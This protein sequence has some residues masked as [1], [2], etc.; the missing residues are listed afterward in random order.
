MID[1]DKELQEIQKNVETYWN[2]EGHLN[3][4]SMMSEVVVATTSGPCRDDDWA[5]PVVPPAPEQAAP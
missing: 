4:W 5:P 3:F 1:N 2:E